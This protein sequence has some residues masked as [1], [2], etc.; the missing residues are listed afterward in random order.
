M[1]DRPLKGRAALV[2]GAGG[3]G[4]GRS[5]ALTLARDGAKVALNFGTYRKGSAA[6]KQTARA[7]ED[8]F[9]SEAVLL[10]G[11]TTKAPACR[12]LVADTVRAFGSIDI[13]VNNAGSP[14]EF[15]PIEKVK[16]AEW[17]KSMAAEIDNVWFLTKYAIPHMR[18]RRFGRVVIFGMFRAQAWRGPPFD[19]T[20]GKAARGLL[21]E[22]LAL[23]LQEDGITVNNIAP[24]FVE[25]VS[26]KAAVTHARDGPPNPKGEE[27]PVPQHAA[28]AI[29]WLCRDEQRWISGAELPVWG[30]PPPKGR[31]F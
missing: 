22:K 4:M 10:R 13:L 1:A 2:T 17:T 21:T 19:G 11:D 7:I 14:W 28:D 20:F 9:G 23:A 16:D 29:A 15:L 3:S 31:K 30:A 18:R 25:W 6:A 27:R 8:E 24:G 12:K 5:T 26:F